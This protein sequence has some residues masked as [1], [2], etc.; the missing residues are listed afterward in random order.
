MRTQVKRIV[1]S[2]AKKCGWSTNARGRDF[3]EKDG[4]EIYF[5]PQN[6]GFE[7]TVRNPDTTERETIL[8]IL[9]TDVCTASPL[10]V[11]I[12][13]HVLENAEKIVSNQNL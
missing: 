11:A 2:S 13:E 9:N 7:L 12:L 5:F 8:Q 3:Y 1:D 4:Y 10:Y 6:G